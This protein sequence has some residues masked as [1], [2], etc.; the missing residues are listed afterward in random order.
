MM[1]EKTNSA[2]NWQPL[3]V[4]VSLGDLEKI[5]NL[6]QQNHFLI[7]TKMPYRNATAL[8]VAMSLGNLEIAE[9]L[10]SEGA[11]ISEV[12]ITEVHEKCLPFYIEKVERLLEEGVRLNKTLDEEP[13]DSED[14]TH[15]DYADYAGEINQTGQFKDLIEERDNG[16][17]VLAEPDPSGWLP[18]Q[19]AAKIGDLVKLQALLK[20]DY[21]LIA[22]KMPFRAATALRVAMG[23]GRINIAKYLLSQGAKI[24]EVDRAELQDTA[25]IALYDQI[26]RNILDEAIKKNK[27]LLRI[28]LGSKLE[29]CT[30]LDY[31]AEIGYL[32]A[33]QKA[34]EIYGNDFFNIH[35]GETPV[36]SA[37]RNNNLEIIKFIAVNIKNFDQVDKTF[38]AFQYAI[39]HSKW[40]IAEILL[41]HGA[42]INKPDQR[43]MSPLHMAVSNGSIDII[44]KLIAYNAD[45]Y[46]TTHYGDTILHTAVLADIDMKQILNTE[47][48]ETLKNIKNLHGQTAQQSKENPLPRPVGQDSLI[49]KVSRYVELMNL[50]KNLL[51]GGYC[52]AITFMDTVYD[53]IGKNEDLKQ[54]FR[55]WRSW[56]G[57]LTALQAEPPSPLNEK[58]QTIGEVFKVSHAAL[59]WFQSNNFI[60]LATRFQQWDFHLQLA[61]F[62]A[63]L[64]KELRLTE[65]QCK[66]YN[67]FPAHLHYVCQFYRPCINKAKFV[68]LNKIFASLPAKTRITLGGGSHLVHFTTNSND[69]SRYF[70]PNFSLENS[71]QLTA[72]LLTNF[73]IG[74]KYDSLKAT[75]YYNNASNYEV[76]FCVYRLPDDGLEYKYNFFADDQLPKTAD[77]VAEFIASATNPNRFSPLHIAILTDSVANTKSLLASGICDIEYKDDNQN[78]ALDLAK[79]AGN[80]SSGLLL[81][82]AQK[83]C[84]TNVN[85]SFKNPSV[86]YQVPKTPKENKSGN[87][88]DDNRIRISTQ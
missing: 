15:R 76:H 57:T 27:N 55:L 82:Y 75:L 80:E 62:N 34:L 70:D 42:D 44:K 3:Q 36:F 8:R 22:K 40:D 69:Q 48:Y 13:P 28:P 10:F 33:F 65:A 81:E 64:Q 86:F 85:S 68:Q 77:E 38:T 52:N 50:N 35:C 32:P 17:S 67:D 73:V 74:T 5:K 56:D 31:A 20:E 47:A 9:Y 79:Q 51:S 46:A 60:K 87:D 61:G 18:L 83:K 11:K 26:I 71:M 78:S 39:I 6:L 43:R 29:T 4:A 25:C 49:P 63:Y 16:I 30:Y 45:I 19:Q 21:S 59:V 88:N 66:K 24:Y 54:I 72:E 23:C 58:Y 1:Q 12:L 41:Q 53:S 84:L 37:I 14:E 2:N 7:S